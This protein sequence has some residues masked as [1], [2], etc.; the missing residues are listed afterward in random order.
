MTASKVSRDRVGEEMVK[1]ILEAKSIADFFRTMTETKVIYKIAPEFSGME[2]TFHDNRGSHYGESVYQHTLDF[3]GRLHFGSIGNKE[4]KLI[5]ALVAYFHDVGKITTIKNKGGKISFLGHE[6]TSAKLAE[7]RLTALRI[8]S[9]II[10]PVVKLISLHMKLNEMSNTSNPLPKKQ[11]AKMLAFD[12]DGTFISTRTS[13]AG[14]IQL[15]QLCSADQNR[16][17]CFPRN[18]SFAAPL[19]TGEDVMPARITIVPEVTGICDDPSDK[20]FGQKI[21]IT[22]A[23]T[24]PAPAKIRGTLLKKLYSL[25][26]SKDLDKAGLQKYLN[27]EANNV[28]SG[29]KA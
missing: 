25:Q 4:E 23:V 8:P 22:P 1:S 14:L 24:E 5:F 7:I 26:L 9:E 6:D 11:F 17:L 18:F 27:S 28:W 16:Q 19:M 3:A 20:C 21:I 29:M 15:I 2:T 13:E 12:F 10:R